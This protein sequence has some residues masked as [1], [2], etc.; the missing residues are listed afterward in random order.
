[1]VVG[2]MARSEEAASL[3]AAAEHLLSW[4]ARQ[5]AVSDPAP[6]S[7]WASPRPGNKDL[8]DIGHGTSRTRTP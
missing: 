7:A 5:I 3:A 4:Q 6:E 1:M 8:A 2:G